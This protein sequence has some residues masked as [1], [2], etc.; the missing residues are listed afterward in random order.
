MKI[1]F[2][3]D[4]HGYFPILPGGDI[5]IIAGDLHARDTPQEYDQFKLWL[6]NQRY[7]KIVM[8]AGNHDAYLE[9]CFKHGIDLFS[10]PNLTYLC[11]SGTEYENLKI[12]GC[13]Y[14]KKFVGQNPRAMAFSV[15]SEFQLKDHFDLIPEQIDILI[16]HS[17]PLGILDECDNGWVGSDMLRQRIMKVKPR[18]CCFGHIH[19]QGGKSM[20]VDN[21]TYINASIV[22]QRYQHV[23]KPTDLEL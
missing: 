15:A 22:N 1:T 13:P 8:I 14:T 5:L 21:T 16:T 18:I 9:Y 7:Q 11:D 20:T 12:W 10:L 4:L 6:E 19:E 23:H 2:I 17:P 3:S